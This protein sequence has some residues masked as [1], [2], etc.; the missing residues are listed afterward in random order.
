L[1]LLG[2]AGCERAANPL[3]ASA[4]PAPAVPVQVAVAVQQDVPR[5]IESIGMVQSQRTVALK[6]QVD[7]VIAK[8]HFREGDDVKAGD[9]VVTVERRRLQ[10]GLE[11]ARAQVADARDE[12]KKA[13]ADNE[14]YKQ[15]AQADAI[16]KEQF[17]QLTTK[18]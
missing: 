12:A 5:R 6:S 13:T 10:H 2:L 11:M 8:I 15:L 3:T 14:R 18:T 9:P 17:T 4:G 16:S 1:L 7:G